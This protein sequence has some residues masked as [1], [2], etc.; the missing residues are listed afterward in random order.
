M[1]KKITE[2]SEKPSYGKPKKPHKGGYDD[3]FR[4]IVGTPASES[5]DEYKAR[6]QNRTASFKQTYVRGGSQPSEFDL[7]KQNVFLRYLAS[8]G[9]LSYSLKQVGISRS[10]FQNTCNQNKEFDALVEEAKQYAADMLEMEARRRAEQG[11]DKGIWHQGDLVGTEKVYSD[12]LMKTLLE[13]HLPEKYRRRS[14]IDVNQTA[15]TCTFADM[16]D[17]MARR[18]D[19]ENV[20]EHYALSNNHRKMYT[21]SEYE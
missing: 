2:N 7:K 16:V 3:R 8:S 21:V 14:S 4:E 18:D 17:Y 5:I 6:R 11:T 20:S 10:T 1:T 15:V 9:N 19:G 13:A 12:S